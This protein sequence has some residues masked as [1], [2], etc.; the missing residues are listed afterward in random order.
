MGE[1]GSPFNFIQEGKRTRQPSKSRNMSKD[2]SKPVTMLSPASCL[3]IVDSK[4]TRA[5]KYELQIEKYKI[6]RLDR[7]IH[8]KT[9][10]M[11]DLQ[12]K[13]S[14]LDMENGDL[15][16]RLVELSILHFS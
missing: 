6:K 2:L 3:P 9:L 13:L 7:E 15:N 10:I 1:L 16:Q 14:S 12:S 4:T 8:E 5:N 11:E